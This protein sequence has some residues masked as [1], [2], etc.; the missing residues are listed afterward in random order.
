[1]RFALFLL[2]I[3]PSACATQKPLP[4]LDTCVPP[5]AVVCQPAVGA[6]YQ[7]PKAICFPTDEWKTWAEACHYR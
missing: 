6:S 1:M 7:T 2:L 5:M 3:L 4:Q